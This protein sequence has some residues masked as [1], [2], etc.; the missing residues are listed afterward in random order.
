[1]PL[2]TQPNWF[3]KAAL[4]TGGFTTLTCLSITK[5][6]LDERR[7]EL[8]L[9]KQSREAEVDKGVYSF[10]NPMGLKPEAMQ[11]AKAALTQAKFSLSHPILSLSD[12]LTHLTSIKDNLDQRKE[13]LLSK[14]RDCQTEVDKGVVSVFNPVGLKQSEM[15][16][17]KIE[18]KKA[19]FNS[20]HPILSWIL[21]K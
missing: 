3:K 18:L 21:R 11:S 4:F 16:K 7:E 10:L 13:S 15:K 1:M 17:A 2:A 19:R 12:R 6:F 9:E 20:S 5:H 14:K 8:F